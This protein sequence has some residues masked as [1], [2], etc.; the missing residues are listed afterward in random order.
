M[1]GRFILGLCLCGLGAC[2]PASAGVDEAGESEA[3]EASSSTSQSASTSEGS[4]GSTESTG[5]S[6][7]D[8]TDSSSSTEESGGE[9]GGVEIF[10]ELDQVGAVPSELVLA[11]E[12]SDFYQQHLDLDGL[13]ILSSDL[14]DPEALVVACEIAEHMLSERPDLH[15]ELIANQIRIGVMSVDEVTTDIPEHAD[16]YEVFPGVDWDV[17]AR[18]LGATLARPASTVGEENLLHFA[19]DPYEGESI[20]VHEFSHTMWGV[21]VQTLP[22]GAQKQQELVAVYQS[23]LAAGLYVDTYAATDVREYWAEAVQSWFN[24]NLEAD[25][26]NGVHNHVNTREEL[27][28]YDPDVIPIIDAVFAD[29]DWV[30]P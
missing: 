11:W 3:S 21:G 28:A 12:L 13:P 5:E 2:G 7:T 16:L 20:M 1:Q 30:V 19:G 22:D 4:Q 8:G 9:S 6:S 29:D 25:P 23:A 18:G 27:V 26:P 14:V 15:A 17:R 24:T 10:C